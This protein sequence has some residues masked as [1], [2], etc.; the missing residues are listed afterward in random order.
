MAGPPPVAPLVGPAA[1]LMPPQAA[2]GVPMRKRGGKVSLIGDDS[3]T[4]IL[5]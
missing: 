1:G 5:G 4:D 3:Q 2:P